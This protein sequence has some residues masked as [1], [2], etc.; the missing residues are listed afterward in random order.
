MQNTS[1][2][3]YVTYSN[4]IEIVDK[5]IN[6]LHGHIVIAAVNGELT[7]KRLSRVDGR[8]RL[9]PENDDFEPIDITK[10]HDLVIWGVVTYVIHRAD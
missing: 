6:A 10:D 1:S 9:M 3:Y 5:S 7:V 2:I 8:V 4:Y